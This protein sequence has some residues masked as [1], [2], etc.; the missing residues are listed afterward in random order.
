MEFRRLAAAALLSLVCALAPVASAQSTNPLLMPIVQAEQ[1]IFVTDPGD[2]R[3][4]IVERAGFIRIFANGGLQAV[5][6]FLDIHTA[7]DATG[8]GGL[9]SMAFDPSFASNRFVYVMYTRASSVTNVVLESVVARY[10][11]Q[12]ADPNHVDL[13]SAKELLVQPAPAEAGPGGNTFT[14]HKGGQLQFGSDG[15]LYVGFGD[16]GSGND[17]GC[18]AQRRNLFYGK[19]LRIDPAGT[20]FGVGGV[21]YGIPADNPFP[22]G[23]DPNDPNDFRPEIW[24]LGLRNPWRFSFDR[25]TGDLWI[26]D[27]GQDAREEVDLQD[28]NAA[29]GANYGWNPVEGKI[30][31]PGPNV[32]CPAYVKPMN[33]PNADYTAPIFDYDHGGGHRSITGGYVY[34]GAVAGWQGRYLY[35]DYITDQVFYLEKN[36]GSW[37]STEIPNLGLV[38]PASFGEDA[39]GELYVADIVDGWVYRFNFAAAPASKAQVA[40]VTSLNEGFAKLANTDGK[41]VKSCVAKVLKGALASDGV[42]TCVTGDAKQAKIAAENAATDAKKCAPAPAFGYAGAATGNAASA[43]VD[44]DSATAVLGVGDDLG[45]G[46]VPKTADKDAAACQKAVLD[47]LTDCMAA[48]RA[49]FVRCKKVGLKKGAIGDTAKLALCL[50][51]DD[52]GRVAKACDGATGKLAT[53]TIDKSCV[54]RE[55]DLSTAFPNCGADTTNELAQCIEAVT[56]CESCEMFRQADALPDDACAAV[57]P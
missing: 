17:P 3:L 19:L 39:N 5:N 53:K 47:G 38:G 18:R 6:A 41:L 14:N 56:A 24:A 2:G 27:V 20:G 50:A 49:E 23:A 10:T 13:A 22:T 40:C 48:R 57:C 8:E 37:E 51:S 31:G 36:G 7:V 54:A 34:R 12:L 32:N 33:D 29:G 45:A 55:V 25:G 9:L 43:S 11:V 15:M 42:A 44:L 4:F 1:P 46:L 21:G 35:A 16:G 28:A 52:N 26:G 30:A